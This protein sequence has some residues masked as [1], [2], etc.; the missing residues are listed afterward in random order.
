LAKLAAISAMAKQLL[1][2]SSWLLASIKIRT[3]YPYPRKTA[4][5]AKTA[6]A[7]WLLTADLRER[8]AESS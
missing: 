5:T 1:A 6:I 8:T 7:K 3:L 4:K 2:I